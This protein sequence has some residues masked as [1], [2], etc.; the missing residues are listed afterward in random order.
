MLNHLNLFAMRTIRFIREVE[1][2]ISAAGLSFDD[3]YV[4]TCYPEKIQLQGK[5]TKSVAL[6]VKKLDPDAQITPQGYIGAVAS[7]VVYAKD[8]DE[9]SEE[10]IYIEITLT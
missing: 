1:A 8:G 2:A 9:S 3:F 5:Y 6:G 4:V 7:I 10:R